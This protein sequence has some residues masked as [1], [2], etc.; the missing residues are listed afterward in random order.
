MF[1]I[2]AHS[3]RQ[4]ILAQEENQPDAKDAALEELQTIKENQTV[5]QS[6]LSELLK[7]SLAIENQYDLIQK[8]YQKTKNA[9]QKAGDDILANKILAENMRLERKRLISEL[10]IL[11]NDPLYFVLSFLDTDKFMS[12]LHG[13]DENTIVVSEKIKKVIEINDLLKELADQEQALTIKKQAYRDQAQKLAQEAL[14]IQQAVAAKENSLSGLSSRRFNLERYL[15]DLE[16]LT[17]NLK[18]DFVGWNSATGPVFEF[19]GGGTE[20]GLGLSQYGAKGMSEAGKNYREI[21]AHYYQG[22]KIGRINSNP[23]VRIGLV[24]HGAGYSLKIIAGAYQIH[25]FKISAGERLQ[26]SSNLI[27]LYRQGQLAKKFALE[28]TERILPLK[29]ESIIQLDYKSSYFNQYTGEIRLI[30]NGQ[31]LTTV[32]VLRLEEYLKGVVV[33]E[34]PHNW[35]KEAIKAQALAARSYAI[36][37]LKK[38]GSYDMD[39]STAFQVYIGAF[40]RARSTHAVE[41]TR[42][43]VVTFAGQIIPTYY[44]STS[45]GY[46]ENN[47]NIWGGKPLPYL[48]GVESPWEESS[49]WWTWYTKKYSRGEIS[50]LLASLSCGQ[51]KKLAIV[52]RGVSGRV[53]AVKIVGS[54]GVRIISG[55]HFKD[56]I[57]SSLGPDDQ[58]MRS[59]LFGVRSIK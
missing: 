34:V 44:F 24:L 6:Q 1:L 45:G 23:Q 42:G 59:T 27:S 51:I 57:N 54:Q 8:R 29:A 33:A 32:N 55:A 47:E 39:D 12:R 46:T 21:L 50:R 4:I 3:D 30:K 28:K 2:F 16:K 58:M 20:H 52:N 37:H 18:R 11:T 40:H 14:K 25:Q 9:A 49:P 17:S 5:Y 31:S 13:K 10:Y 7:K 19:V 43:E 36:R 48:R 35:P 15:V 41:E 26:V 38:T 56:L 53:L 22:T